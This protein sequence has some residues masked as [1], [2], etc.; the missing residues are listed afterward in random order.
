VDYILFC[1]FVLR[2]SADALFG[3]LPIGVGGMRLTAGALLNLVIL[4]VAGTMILARYRPSIPSKVWIPYLAVATLS[5][6]WAQDRTGALRALLVLL[7]YAS[8]FALPFYVRSSH[9]DN[10]WLLRAIVYSSL[11][12]AIYGFAE[13]F[14]FRD[15]SGRIKSTFLHPNVFGCYLNIVVG[16]VCYLVSAQTVQASPWVKRFL[17]V[18]LVPLV[19]LV[20]MTQARVAW[21]G[22]VLV[23]GGYAT[24]VDRRF[25]F[26]LVFFPLLIYVPTV[27]D[28]I[29]DL[30]RGTAVTADPGE[31]GINSYAWRELMWESALKDA[32]DAPILGRGLASFGQNAV[33][34]F[35]LA[36][37]A[38]TYGDLGLRP[39]SVYIQT[40]YELGAVGFL[41]YFSMY[42]G[43]IWVSFRNLPH[44]RKGG[45]IVIIIIGAYMLQSYSDNIL[46][47]GSLNMYFWGALGTIFAKWRRQESLMRR[48]WNIAHRRVRAKVF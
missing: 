29:L 40:I 31:E 8:L 2:A 26:A 11:I 18:Y 19:A 33:R 30:E 14:F 27:S 36:R 16:T 41:C 25:L 9:R 6:T 35:P 24:L 4:V 42:I 10:L 28:R 44:D 3:E 13:F 48:T 23:L 32:A 20:V 7:T 5:V 43:L 45:V 34:F 38:S 1:I 37:D 22:T 12:P 17:I 39:H 15:D 46:D 21:A 47:Y